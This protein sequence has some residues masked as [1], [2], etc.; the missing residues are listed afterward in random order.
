[1]TEST[2]PTTPEEIRRLNRD[3][4]EKVI[5]KAASD[6]AWKQRFLDNPEEAIQE[7]DF[8]ETEGLQE[9]YK[10]AMAEEEEVAGQVYYSP[11]PRTPIYRPNPREY[12]GDEHPPTY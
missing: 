7:A 12:P 9:A 10:G 8:P 2:P 6:P 3:L 1:M 5:D 4:M 11:E